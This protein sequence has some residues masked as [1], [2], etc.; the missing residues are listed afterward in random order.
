M[1]AK[2]TQLPCPNQECICEERSKCY[3]CGWWEGRQ[4]G[5]KEVWKF[6]DK[7][8]LHTGGLEEQQIRAMDCPV[9]WQAKLKEWG[10]K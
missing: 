4:A 10:I 6:M 1:E 2:D 9:C 7:P 3:S 5:I 8:C